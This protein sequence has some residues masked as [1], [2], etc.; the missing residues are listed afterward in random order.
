MTAMNGLV[1]WQVLIFVVTVFGGGA[2]LA[3]FF[4][5]VISKQ[6]EAFEKKIDAQSAAFDTKIDEASVKLEKQIGVI[7]LMA[8]ADRVQ[9]TAKL[10]SFDDRDRHEHKEML[11]QITQVRIAVGQLETNKQRQNRTRKK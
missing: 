9:I 1:D 11:E 3:W 8:K 7:D 10:E 2:T 6:S 4:S 5:N